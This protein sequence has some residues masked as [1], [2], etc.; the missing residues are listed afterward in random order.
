MENPI[1]GDQNGS[2]IHRCGRDPKV[3]FGD[4][5]AFGFHVSLNNRVLISGPRRNC[6]A[7][8]E[9]EKPIRSRFQ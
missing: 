4:W 7:R 6:F 1:P 9:M 8:N 2:K 5:R 3:T